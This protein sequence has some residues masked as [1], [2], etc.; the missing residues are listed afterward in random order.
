MNPPD[1]IPH[2]TDPILV[3]DDEKIFLSAL[4]ETLRR[5]G[6]EAVACNSPLDALAEL[7]RRKFAVI[8]SDQLMPELT[9]LELLAQARQIQPFATRVLATAVLN[10]DTVIAAINK[11]EIFRFIIKPWLH[12][13]FIATVKNAVQRYQLICQNA[14]LQASTQ[15]MNAQLVDLNRSL[16]QQLQLTSQQNSKL[17]ELN[18]ALETNLFRSL[19]LCIHTMQTFYPSLGTQ[20]RRVNQLARVMGQLAKLSPDEQ[21]TL[22]SAALLHDIGLVGIPRQ[23]I[24]RWQENPDSL[25]DAERALIEQHPILGQELAA[26]VSQLDQVGHII[27]GHHERLDGRGYPDQRVGENIPWLARLLAVPAA[28]ASYPINDAAAIEKI[29]NGADTAFDPIAVRIFLQAQTMAQ[30]PRR[31]RQI[32]LN[33]LR[34]GMVLATGIYTPNGLLL[35]PEGKTLNATYIEKVLNY[36]RFQPLVQALTVYC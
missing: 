27:R 29:K 33:E 20:A 15:S 2:S 13:E 16:E 6:Y 1:E 36:N 12:E 18:T 26:F 31:E 30:V 25:P 28:F 17:G 4:H 3:V 19:E 5:A 22:E 7:R 34:P 10:L 35:V 32:N 9:G 14:H 11:G 8:I 23:I 24:R 21:R